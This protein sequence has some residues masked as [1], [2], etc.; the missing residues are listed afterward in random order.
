MLAGTALASSTHASLSGVPRIGFATL[1]TLTVLF[2]LAASV[3]TLSFGFQSA[4]ATRLRQQ[5]SDV[6]AAADKSGK[7]AHEAIIEYTCHQLK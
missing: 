4:T 7:Q 3:S 2:V 1:I 6:R 5:A